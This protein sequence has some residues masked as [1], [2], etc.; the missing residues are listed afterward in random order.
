MA[1]IQKVLY[2]RKWVETGKKTLMRKETR[3]KE[4]KEGG[5]EEGKEGGKEKGSTGRRKE[6]WEVKR[7]KQEAYRNH[8]VFLRYYWRKRERG[9]GEE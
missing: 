1:R 4:G 5:R 8:Q 7:E 9:V 3:K 2:I 6:G